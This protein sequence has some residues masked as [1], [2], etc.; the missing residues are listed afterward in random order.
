MQSHSSPNPSP[1]PRSPA[2]RRPLFAR[3]LLLLVALG[4]SASQAALRADTCATAK[5]FCTGVS[6]SFPSSTN[7]TAESGPDY[8]C[9]G[10]QPNPSWYYL[11]IGTSGNIVIGIDQVDDNGVPRDVDFICWGPFTSP[12]T[13]CTGLLT[14]GNIVDCS[15]S[16]SA[17]ETCTIPAAVVGQYYIL[18]LTNYSNQ[19]AHITFSQT[20][21]TG[22]TDCS[23]TPTVG[24]NK[25][26]Q[27]TTGQ[28]ADSI[29]ILLQGSY[30]SVVL[31]YDGYPAN[32][33]GTFALVPSGSNTLLRWTNPNFVVQP[34]AIAHVG[35]Q[36]PGTVVNVLGVFWRSNGVVTGCAHQCSGNTHYSGTAGGVV[37]YANNCLACEQVPLYA[38][39][40][41]VE[42]F[43]DEVPLADLN[44]S[45]TRNPLQVD[46]IQQPPLLLTPGAS[47]QVSVPAGPAGAQFALIVYKVSASPT[48][49]GPDVTLDFAQFTVDAPAP[50]AMVPY[51]DP[52]SGGVIACPCGNP[53][54]GAGRGCDNSAATG[55]ATLSATGSAS[56]ASDT[57][58]FT[59]AGQRPTGTTILLQGTTSIAPGVAFGQGVRC[60]GGALKRL[61]VKSASGGGFAAPA[62]ADLPVSMRS[63]Q[64]GDNI[65]AGSTRYYLAYYRDPIVLG[66]CSSNSTFNAGNSGSVIWN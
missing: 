59:T 29:E 24:V 42:W 34:N 13:P 38:G 40:L 50:S 64:L 10:S 53:P 39:D 16:T 33:F 35:F 3:A 12:V 66:G 54:A 55:G 52:G 26:L 5:P 56:L 57:L 45:A 25:D 61:Y 27:N 20:G 63:A 19:P 37:E 36:V 43:V 47:A 49:A 6:Y 23:I 48:L 28:T 32:H 41:H 30:S 8:G 58:V 9:L 2:A 17:S 11:K 44:P 7:G 51:C 21:G 1:L 65:A 22:A 18:L 31:H 15:Y 62:G 46:T 60:V 4:A 14:A